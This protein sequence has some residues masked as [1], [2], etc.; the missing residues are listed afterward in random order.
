MHISSDHKKY[1]LPEKYGLKMLRE[2]IK[3][4]WF[5]TRKLIQNYK[6]IPVFNVDQVFPKMEVT[7]R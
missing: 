7:L 1:K 2:K 5:N 6:R 4:S 3:L